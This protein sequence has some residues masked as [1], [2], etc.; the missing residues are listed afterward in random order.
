MRPGVSIVVLSYNRPGYLREALASIAA[1]T[2]SPAEVLVVDNASPRQA[3]VEEVVR[4]FPAFRWVPQATNLGFTGGMNAGLRQSR[5]DYVLLTEDDIVLEPQALEVLVAHAQANPGHALLGGMMLNRGSR[6]VRCV[7][8]EVKLGAQFQV[9]INGWN[10]PDDGRFVEPFPVGY[11][12]GAFLFASRP[13]WSALG[14]F[15]ELYFMYQEDVDLCLRLRRAGWPIVIV[16]KARIWHFEPGSGADVPRW[17]EALKVRNLFRLYI[18]NAPPRVLPGFLFR[19]L[20]VQPFHFLYRRHYLSWM[21]HREWWR[22]V[23]ELPRLV[24]ERWRDRDLFQPPG[25]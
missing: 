12:P 2:H 14:G 21:I 19:T 1:Q 20:V 6:T 8:G 15:R 3:E 16:P 4:G 11:I 13:T 9:R 18:L 7:G 22:V 5:C 25:G 17:L 10:T 24:R 23:L